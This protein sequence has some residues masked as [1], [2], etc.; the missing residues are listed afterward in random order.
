MKAFF[1][2]NY[3]P[4]ETL[5]MKEVAK[6]APGENEVLIKV[7]ATAVN[8]Y[9]WSFVRGKPFIYRLMFG[10]QKP[11]KPIPG[12]ELA[13][14][15]EATGNSVLDFKPGDEVYG[16]VSDS[17]FGSFAEYLAIDQKAVVRKP[18]AMSFEEAASLSHAFNLAAQGLIDLGQISRG[19]KVLINGG[20]GGVG[21]LGLQL[22]RP[23]A[24]EICGVDTGDKLEMMNRMG[25]DEVIDYKETDFTR[26]GK[27]YDLILDTKT[28][29]SPFAY[30]RALNRGGKYITVGGQLTKLFQILLFKGWIRRSQKK[31]VA[32]VGLK[33]NKD[34]DLLHQLYSEGKITA[35]IDGPYAFE[36]T[37]EALRRF[38]E[39][40]HTGKVIIK[41]AEP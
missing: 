6:P 1:L 22:A 12:M 40:K 28:N 20:G 7:I 34:L 14:I 23:Y 10:L 8:D 21:F 38:G 11:K 26:S 35:T 19:Q 36:E 4:P 30:A 32:M 13:G 9:D 33:A 39:G 3:G 31:R 5:M 25:Y 41:V 15:I 2:E 16:D 18:Q 27:T 37:P 29:R 17:G 24:S